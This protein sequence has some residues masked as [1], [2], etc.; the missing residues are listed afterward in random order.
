MA[1]ACTPSNPPYRL[2]GF[3]DLGKSDEF[4]TKMLENRLFEM[5]ELGV[6]LFLC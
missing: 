2:V 5:G 1:C 4:T 6:S 3:E